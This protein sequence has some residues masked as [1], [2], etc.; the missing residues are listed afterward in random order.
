MLL[1]P[2]SAA[3]MGC[4]GEASPV[5]GTASADAESDAPRPPTPTSCR[6][7]S[8]RPSRTLVCPYSHTHTCTHIRTAAHLLTLRSTQSPVLTPLLRR[9]V[10][11]RPLH[12]DERASPGRAHRAQRR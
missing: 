2:S 7:A 11:Q 4:M 3:R 8:T 6:R 5:G 10:P 1:P 12:R 9:L